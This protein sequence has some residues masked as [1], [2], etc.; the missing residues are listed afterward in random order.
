MTFKD[1]V[2]E[3]DAEMVVVVVK[4]PVSPLVEVTLGMELVP[5]TVSVLHCDLGH[6]LCVDHCKYKISL[7][8]TIDNIPNFFFS[9][10]NHKNFHVLQH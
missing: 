7:A 10:K 6:S 8:L 5:H 4:K 3:E 9:Q 1:V 2:V